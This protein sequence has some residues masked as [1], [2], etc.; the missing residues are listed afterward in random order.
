MNKLLMDS[1]SISALE[2]EKKRSNAKTLGDIIKKYRTDTSSTLADVATLCGITK[3]YVAMLEKN[4]NSKTGR[5]VKP[6]IETILKVCAGLHLDIEQVFE[7]LYDDYITTIPTLKVHHTDSVH[8]LSQQDKDF[9]AYLHQLNEK[10][11][12]ILLSYADTL[13][14]SGKYIK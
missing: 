7:D 13:V 8:N 3:G 10:G 2:N 14:L 4:V 11:Q 12:K 6:T 5:P 1:E 9:L